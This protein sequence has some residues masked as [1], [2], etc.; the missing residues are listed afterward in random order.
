MERE[1]AET[2][3]WHLIRCQNE[4]EKPLS[5]VLFMTVTQLLHSGRERGQGCKDDGR[6]VPGAWVQ[7]LGGELEGQEVPC[8]QEEK[9]V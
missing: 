1:D 3:T 2:E 6:S 7:S 8:G 9:G 5:S 4:V